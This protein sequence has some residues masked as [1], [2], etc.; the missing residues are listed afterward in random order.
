M[1]TLAGYVMGFI[2]GVIG[3]IASVLFLAIAEGSF[4]LRFN[5]KPVEAQK[6]TETT[7]E[8]DDKKPIGFAKTWNGSS[9]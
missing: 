4:E 2:S 7:K 5:G 3:T 1:K 8:N 9:S 6:K